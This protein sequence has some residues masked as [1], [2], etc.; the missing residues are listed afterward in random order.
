MEWFVRTPLLSMHRMSG[1]SLAKH[2][3]FGVMHVN[4]RIHNGM[5]LSWGMLLFVSALASVRCLECML[6]LSRLLSSWTT[7][8]CLAILSMLRNL[9]SYME[10]K[11][12]HVCLSFLWHNVQLRFVYI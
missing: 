5:V 9:F 4:L 1:L 10:C 12:G 2:S 8:L 6:D 3:Q 11:C 7:M